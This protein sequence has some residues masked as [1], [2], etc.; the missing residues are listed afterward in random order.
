L[1]AKRAQVIVDDYLRRIVSGDMT[2]GQ[3]LPTET[4]MIEQYQV[5][6]TAVREAI[7]ALAT[8]GFVQIRQGSGSTVAPR[9]RWNVLDP[10]YLQITGFGEAIFDNLL[11]TRDILEPAIAGLAA[12][13]A[14]PED[15]AKLRRLVTELEEAGDKDAAVHADLDIE[16][17]H[18]L[19]EATGNPVLISLHGSISHLSRVQREIM[20]ARP[21]VV[22]RA[23]FWHQHIA[24]AV[25]SGDADAGRDAMRMHLRQVHTDLDATLLGSTLD[26]EAE[27]PVPAGTD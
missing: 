12:E 18:A 10:D 21:G 22:E 14:A 13:R 3:L 11:E 4:V 17:H 25:A 23:V 6:R 26:R 7:Q 16:F 5:S 2:E 1:V 9:L 24:D 8:K 19:A 27:Q 15:V 20:V